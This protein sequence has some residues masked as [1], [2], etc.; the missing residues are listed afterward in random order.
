MCDSTTTVYNQCSRQTGENTLQLPQNHSLLSRIRIRLIGGV[1]HTNTSITPGRTN[2]RGLSGQSRRSTRPD[3]IRGAARRAV[4]PGQ[5]EL[6][7]GGRGTGAAAHGGEID[8]EPDTG[9]QVGL[10]G[11]GEA[12]GD[13][14]REVGVDGHVG[15]HR[16]G[17]P[18]LGS[19]GAAEGDGGDAFL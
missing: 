17:V 4:D 18:G 15:L 3:I 13:V 19:R 11:R 8:V 2:H 7:V 16:R 6:E 1:S 14:R 5:H 12:L 10:A 9:G